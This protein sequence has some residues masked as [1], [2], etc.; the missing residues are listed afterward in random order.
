MKPATGS[1]IAEGAMGP[2]WQH[3]LRWNSVLHIPSCR[4]LVSLIKRKLNSFKHVTG[5]RETG[6]VFK[7][8]EYF[9]HICFLALFHTIICSFFLVFFLYF[10]PLPVPS[11]FS[12]SFLSVISYL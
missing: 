5:L 1:P 7:E 2:T 3:Q 4:Q 8:F 6:R 10:F 12:L 11:C 9:S